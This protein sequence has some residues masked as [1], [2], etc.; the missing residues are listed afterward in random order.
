MVDPRR[1]GRASM[2]EYE[3]AL[4]DVTS[5]HLES[6]I[7]SLL[8]NIGKLF[9]ATLS[10]ALFGARLGP[11]LSSIA[12]AGIILVCATML[13]DRPLWFLWVLMTFLMMIVAI[14]PLDRYFL[15][16][17]PLMIFAWWQGI[18]WLNLRLANRSPKWADWIFAVLFMLG[19]ATNLMRIGEFVVEQRHSHFLYSYKDGRYASVERVAKM[20]HDRVGEN[21]WVITT[22]KFSRTLTFLSH[23]TIVGPREPM[24]APGSSIAFVLE[25]M[26]DLVRQRLN[27]LGLTEGPPV[28]PEIKSRFD[29]EPWRLRRAE[30]KQ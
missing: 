18:R 4:F 30:P 17:I 14:E 26:D 15:E 8:P 24:Q 29:P 25:P 28:G 20:L 1:G 19:G 5:A 22:A 11:G 3:D 7:H 21:A 12:G 6:V 13:L 2:G 16:V 23:R 27:E 9:E 10:Q